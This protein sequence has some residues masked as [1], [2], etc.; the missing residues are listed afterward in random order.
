MTFECE[1]KSKNILEKAIPYNVS[2]FSSK[3]FFVTKNRKNGPS[4]RGRFSCNRSYRVKN[5]GF[6]AD[7]KKVN[8]P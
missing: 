1:R 2:H 7:T 3:L 8:M 6:Y 5:R 4:I